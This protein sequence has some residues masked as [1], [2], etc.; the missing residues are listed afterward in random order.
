MDSF[1]QSRVQNQVNFDSNKR[2]NG[3]LCE[4]QGGWIIFLRPF[5]STFLLRDDAHTC[6]HI[7][8]SKTRRFQTIALADGAKCKG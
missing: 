4:C 6:T 2:V 1:I 3:D 7:L 8:F 5:M